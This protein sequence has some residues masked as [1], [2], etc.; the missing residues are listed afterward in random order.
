MEP[1]WLDRLRGR[2]GC[3]TGSRGRS[4]RRGCA[5]SSELA[6][7]ASRS[8]SC[9]GRSPSSASPCSRSSGCSRARVERY[10]AAEVGERVGIELELPAAGLAGARAG[11]RRRRR[12]A[13]YTDRDIEARE[14]GQ[15]AA[16]RRDPRGGGARGRPPARDDDVAARGGEQAAD[17]RRLH[18][19]GRHRVRRRLPF[20]RRRRGVHAADRRDASVRAAHCTCASRSATTPSRSPSSPPAGSRRPTRSTVCFA[21]LVGFTQ[22][23]ETLEPEAL[24]AVTGRLAELAAGAVAAAGPAGEDDRRRRDAGRPRPGGGGR[25]GAEAGRD[26][27]RARARSSRC[28]GRGWPAGQAL[29]RAGDWYGRP[30]NLASRVTGDRAAGQ[31]ARATEASTTGS[32]TSTTGR[33]R[34]SG[35]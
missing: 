20:R 25:F 1:R 30:V 32:R 19:R 15:G 26:G 23:G 7:R 27:V 5:C 34:A 35:G 6:S 29:P 24:G 9:G 14:A 10:T 16:R 28:C 2:E 22:L 17:R 13:I 3:S 21:D 18:A 8:R 12:E 33:S 11:A 31:P 4:A